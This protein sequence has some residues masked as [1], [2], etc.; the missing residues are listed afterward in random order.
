MLSGCA[1]SSNRSL[2]TSLISSTTN[3]F[4]LFPQVLLSSEPTILLLQLKCN[5][6][7]QSQVPY[8]NFW[9][10]LKLSSLSLC[11]AQNLTT[12][13]LVFFLPLPSHPSA[14]SQAKSF[15][16]DLLIQPIHLVQWPHP[17]C[18]SLLHPFLSFSVLF[19]G[20]CHSSG[21]FHHSPSPP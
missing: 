12:F 1:T 2:R 14:V 6:Y 9:L 3:L 19:S 18:W 7:L 4:F 17:I 20:S 10:F 21:S 16:P 13:F 8:H 15:L 5:V 11:W